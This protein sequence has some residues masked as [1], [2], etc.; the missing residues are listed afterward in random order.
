MAMEITRRFTEEYL[1]KNYEAVYSV[2]DN[3]DHIHSHII[4]NSVRW[5]DGRKYRYEKGDWA[6]HIQ[7]LTNRL[8]AERGLS[9]IDIEGS[10]QKDVDKYERSED[11]KRFGGKAV[12]WSQM[13]RN[14]IDACIELAYSY[15]KFIAMLEEK[16]Y[17]V[18]NAHGEGKYIAVK[19]PGRQRYRRLATLGSDYSE[20]RIRE[21]ILTDSVGMSSS[22]QSEEKAGFATGFLELTPAPPRMTSSGN[23]TTNSA[24]SASSTKARTATHGNTKMT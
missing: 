12:Q 7:P 2:H 14:D 19:P 9:I 23:V 13:I 20:G 4:F 10:K 5:T 21:R 6:K 18:K 24:I 1:A 22:Y 11:S 8:C 15:D 17:E 3:T 16:G